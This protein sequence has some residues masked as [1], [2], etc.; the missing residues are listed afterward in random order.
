M[1]ASHPDGGVHSAVEWLLRTW[2]QK[3]RVA[4][5]DQRLPHGKRR[6]DHEWYLEIEGYTM[7]V[8]TAPV[9][10]TMGSPRD[11]VGR[12]AAHEEDC[13]TQRITHSFAISTKEVTVEQFWR[14]QSDYQPN[15]RWP[16]EPGLPATGLSIQRAM[17]YCQWLSQQAEL[18]PEEWCYDNLPG[19]EGQLR[20]RKDCQTRSGYRVPTEEEWEYACRA[21]VEA[22]R[23][24]G[25]SDDYLDYYEW[26][27]ANSG[28]QIH[29]VGRLKPNG[30]GLFDA[31]G[32]V[33]E[34]CLGPYDWDH[35]NQEDIPDRYRRVLESGFLY[36]VRGG[37]YLGH[38]T[39][40]RSACRI[41]SAGSK[42]LH[43]GFRIARSILNDAQK[44]ER[45]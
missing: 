16:S 7:V 19:V 13:R 14:F 28:Q 17:Q 18:L 43:T 4:E 11:E 44:P 27:A 9:E 34:W 22:S 36:P 12:D 37:S 42:T 40:S 24:Y 10:F 30:F 26:S 20:V 8:V 1:Y 29:P 31:L 21:G 38:P 3:D 35:V 23:H 5:V 39:R 45:R 41:P 32:N 2:G 25:D 6:T 15:V 33:S